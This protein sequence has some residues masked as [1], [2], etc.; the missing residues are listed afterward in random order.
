MDDNYKF[1]IWFGKIILWDGFERFLY[2]L[3][4]LDVGYS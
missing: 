4:F 2:T 3:I 1:K